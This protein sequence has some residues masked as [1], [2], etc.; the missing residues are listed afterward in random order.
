MAGIFGIDGGN[1]LKNGLL[2]IRPILENIAPPP[3]E[4]TKGT[5]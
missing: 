5:L 2:N 3:N 1:Y 4:T